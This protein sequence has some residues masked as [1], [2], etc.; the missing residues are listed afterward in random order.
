MLSI[1]EDETNID[2]DILHAQ[3]EPSHPQGDEHDHA[4]E[5][6]HSPFM[7]HFN[8]ESYAQ[9]RLKMLPM[10][11]VYV[12]NGH[13]FWDDQPVLWQLLQ[14][15][16]RLYLGQFVVGWLATGEGTNLPEEMVMP[17]LEM[18]HF[19][20]VATVDLEV[21]HEILLITSTHSS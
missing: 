13:D 6:N 3:A 20:P 7:L 4:T 1:I 15:I 11:F 16:G 21:P 2:P 9:A 5:Y 12:P 18:V 8:A 14:H 19:D 10:L 17:Y